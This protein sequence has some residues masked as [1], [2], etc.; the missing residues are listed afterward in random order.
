MKIGKRKKKR[1]E[2]TNKKEKYQIKGEK[3]MSRTEHYDL[4]E[5]LSALQ[6]DIRRGLEEEALIFALEL[7]RALFVCHVSFCRWLCLV[8]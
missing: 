7:A 1:K 8:R 5:V 6:K 3:R 2:R 4:F